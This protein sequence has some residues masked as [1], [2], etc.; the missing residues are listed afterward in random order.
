MEAWSIWLLAGLALGAGELH[1][2]GLI[3]APVA[4]GALV[5]GGASLA[6]LGPALSI[7]TFLFLST[8]MLRTLRPLALRHQRSSG[9]LRT[10][11]AALVGHR[12][13]VV[14]R[15]AN[16]ESPELARGEANTVFVIPSEFTQA[17][18]SIGEAISH[19]PA[20]PAANGSALVLDVERTENG[21][22]PTDD[23][24]C[25]SGI[26]RIPRRPAGWEAGG[27]PSTSSPTAGDGRDLAMDGEAV[28][29][30]AAAVIRIP[31]LAPCLGPFQNFRFT[32]A[33]RVSVI[34]ASYRLSTT[35]RRRMSQTMKGKTMNQPTPSGIARAGSPFARARRKREIDALMDQ[36]VSWREACAVVAAAYQT[37]RTAEPKERELAFTRYSA[38]LDREEEAATA[39]QVAVAR[40]AAA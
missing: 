17:F 20:I 30:E 3:L 7:L 13:I 28:L 22:G 4:V 24:G 15:I 34:A 26:C 32:Q 29:V 14:E 25:D 40:V 19:R 27:V 36:Y 5:A 21:S 23:Q 16:D 12:A 2:R 37:W 38:A 9:A 1:T 11:P 35:H 31:G 39:Y 6:G 33:G 18:A 8:V 10:G